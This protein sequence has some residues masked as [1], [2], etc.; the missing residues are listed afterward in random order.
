[1]A[2]QLQQLPRPHQQQTPSGV[3]TFTWGMRLLLFNLHQN[4][5]HEGWHGLSQGISVNGKDR[6]SSLQ[7]ALWQGYVV[8]ALVHAAIVSCV[9]HRSILADACGV[10]SRQHCG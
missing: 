7:V 6:R 1:M 9:L 4:H 3:C 5:Q 8:A 2:A 10:H